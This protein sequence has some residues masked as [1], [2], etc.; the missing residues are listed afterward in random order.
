MLF[1]FCTVSIY[2]LC[3]Q[4]R[5]FKKNEPPRIGI[6]LFVPLHASCGQPAVSPYYTE[7]PGWEEKHTNGH[8]ECLQGRD[9]A[10]VGNMGREMH[11]LCLTETETGREAERHQED[12]PA[13][14]KVEKV[15][16]QVLGM[17][18]MSRSQ[19]G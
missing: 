7:G 13:R 16:T 11:T 10:T 1:G 9:K 15:Q 19:V 2:Y 8:L 5:Q 3:K 18:A 6:S 4:K 12:E 17:G 14:G